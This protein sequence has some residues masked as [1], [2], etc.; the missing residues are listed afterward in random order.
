MSEVHTTESGCDLNT[1]I[2]N[3]QEAGYMFLV[4]ISDSNKEARV[5]DVLP[6]N[7]CKYTIND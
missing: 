7:M 2:I 6:A 4:I 5:M 3:A 1:K